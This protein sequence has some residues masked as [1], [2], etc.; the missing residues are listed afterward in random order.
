MTRIKPFQGVEVGEGEEK[1]KKPAK[2]LSTCCIN[3]GFWP[4]LQNPHIGGRKTKS[5]VLSLTT[6]MHCGTPL[7]PNIVHHAHT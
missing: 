5:T 6:Y 2:W 3:L 1:K 7:L 4:N